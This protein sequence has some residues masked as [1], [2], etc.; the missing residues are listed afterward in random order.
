MKVHTG[1]NAGK[2]E[3]VLSVG[4]SGNWYSNKNSVQLP[5][6][7]KSRFPYDPDILLLGVYPK[8]LILYN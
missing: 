7:T 1:M 4:K 3:H 5:Q 2:D 8:D 6:N